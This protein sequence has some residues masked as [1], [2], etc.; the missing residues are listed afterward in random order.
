MGK[1]EGKVV[2]IT[3][4][5]RGQGRS[6]AIRLAEE[7]A[8]IIA[9]DICAQIPLVRY[10]LPD[11]GD[12]AET[13]REVE[14]RGR[15]CLAFEADARDGARMREVVAEAVGELGRL[16]T[17]VVNHG[18]VIPHSPEDEDCDRIWDT[19]VDV[20]LTAAWR[21]VT[22]SIPHLRDEG[23]SIVVIGSAA[24]LMGVYGNASYVAA[25]HGLIGMVKALAQDLARYSIRVNAV[26]PGTVN[27]PLTLN[28]Y[29]LSTFLPGKPDA[30]FAD[31]EWPLRAF[32]LL[33]VPWVES[34]AISEAVLFLSSDSGKY[35]TGIAL[36]VDAGMTT[37]APGI[38]PVIGQ[39]L[40]ELA[41]AADADWFRPE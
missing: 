31:M 37:Q 23:G 36:P 26:C 17:V 2:L 14:A 41:H 20:L 30:T 1:M 12:L 28:D 9:T 7:G 6:H 4:A 5:A 33:P 34:E 27:T 24:S 16:D 39:R 19:V 15:R 40:A 29:S 22:A 18:I 32:N 35:I 13:V 21:T 10:E 3:G 25:K 38:S 11:S 8:D